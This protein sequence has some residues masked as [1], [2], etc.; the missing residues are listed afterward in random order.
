M[1]LRAHGSYRSSQTASLI[2]KLYFQVYDQ[3]YLKCGISG[4][5]C[6]DDQIKKN[7]FLFLSEIDIPRCFIVALF[8]LKC[9]FLC[10]G[11][12]KVKNPEDLSADTMAK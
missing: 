12:T 4:Y 6:N 2:T 9:A 1:D 10:V 11:D 5:N 3:I 7:F 8:I